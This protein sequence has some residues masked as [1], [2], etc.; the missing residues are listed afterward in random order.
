MKQKPGESIPSIRPYC[1]S[2]ALPCGCL[3]FRKQRSSGMHPSCLRANHLA[4]NC[5]FH[6]RI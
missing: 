2:L 1:I 6:S 4:L 3:S 5:L